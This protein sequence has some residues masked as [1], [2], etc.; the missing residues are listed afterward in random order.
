MKA[1]FFPRFMLNYKQIPY[2]TVWI[3]FAD[4][5]SRLKELGAP[6]T[7][8]AAD[9]ITPFYSLP[10]IYDPNTE[11]F[12]SDSIEITKYLDATYPGTTPLF[13][14]P[15]IEQQLLQWVS[16]SPMYFGVRTPL[17]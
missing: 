7:A 6:S 11:K 10:T 5:Q 1:K 14:P 2:K 13:I 16:S 17:S 9:G 4:V 8:T 3:E 12:V 15:A